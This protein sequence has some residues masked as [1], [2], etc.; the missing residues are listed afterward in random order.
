MQSNNNSFSNF[1][2]S[3]FVR[4]KAHYPKNQNDI[5]NLLNTKKSLLVYGKGKSYGDSC[6]NKKNI[7]ILKSFNKILS[8][9]IKNGTL[10][11]EA[12][13]TLNKIVKLITKKG[14]FV[15]VTPGTKY[16]TLGGMLA[17]NIHGKNIKK[18]Y[19]VDHVMSFKIIT[20]NGKIKLCTKK[21][22]KNLFFTTIGGLGLTGVILSV[23][24]KLKKIKSTYM[25]LNKIFNEDT[26]YL[27]SNMEK[28]GKYEYM[29]IWLDSFPNNN[30]VKN[31]I[32]LGN[33]SNVKRFDYSTNPKKINFIEKFGFIFFNNYFFYRFVTKFYY[34]YNK[35]F[36]KKIIHMDKYFYAQDKYLDWNLL[37]GS[38]GFLQF[39][40]L[41]PN[42]NI[43]KFLNEFYN[44]CKIF[45]VYSNLI[46]AKPQKKKI[47]FLNFYG[48]GFSLSFDFKNS[49]KSNLIK[50]F[51]LKNALKFDYI[52]NYSKD[53]YSNISHVPNKYQYNLFKRKLDKINKFKSFNSLL[54]KRIKIIK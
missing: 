16:L 6:L 51:F 27:S 28:F 5:L 45:K 40:I 35:I 31:I 30:K 53:L 47:K 41:I 12:G 44:F 23:K 33:H 39:Q 25:S 26:K 22:N 13:I 1:T 4:P 52:F 2:R 49:K 37:Y 38:K 11:A 29:Y 24:F 14:W 19:F 54:S 42:N 36:N 50:N 48:T 32:F 21:K 20:P 34:F 43:S 8:F 46:V 17:N 9:D 18:N 10:N 3:K 15:P 7:I